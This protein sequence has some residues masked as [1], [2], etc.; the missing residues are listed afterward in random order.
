MATVQELDQIQDYLESIP[1]A[2]EEY[3]RR[4]AFYDQMVELEKKIT[5]EDQDIDSWSS[6]KPDDNAWLEL[7]A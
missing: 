4:L 1:T 7:A 2:Q 5:P 6:I 3:D